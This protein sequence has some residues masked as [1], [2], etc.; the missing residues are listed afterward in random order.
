M[1][2]LPMMVRIFILA[3]WMFAVP[4]VAGNCLL[5]AAEDRTGGRAARLLF[6]WI[7]GQMLLWAGFQV[8]CVPLVL[9]EQNFHVL[10][11]AFSC[12]GAVLFLCGLTAG[13]R[14]RL[15]GKGLRVLSG[16]GTKTRADQMSR[17]YWAVFAALLLLQ[18]VL[19]VVLTYADG[20]DAY[21]VAVSTLTKNSDIMYRSL[22]YTGGTTEIDIR[23][24][25]APF[26]IWISFLSW[27]S[28]LGTAAVAHT[29]VP[30]ML[31]PMTYGI[32]YLLG[33]KLFSDKG[34]FLPLFLIFTELLVI[35]GGYSIYTA[36]HFMIARSRQG[37]TVLG[38]IVIPLLFLLLL[39]LY[40]KLQ[41]GKKCGPAYWIFLLGCTVT[42]CLC[43]TMGAVLICMLLGAA[44]LC[45]AVCYRRWRVLVPLCLCCLPCVVCALL[46]VALG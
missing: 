44:G 32:F 10:A 15:V 25:L 1:E 26:P 16:T 22:P 37:K 34:E 14:R 5:G 17:I 9:K 45:G 42:G 19:T 18:L 23:H 20:D 35:F 8:I 11:I 24:G 7:G 46:Y 2:N 3:F 27:T 4:A 29:G 39:T 40:E 28:G 36:E 31:I 6:C 21:Y 43:S 38:S 33:R 41:R 30:L 13:L 12:Y